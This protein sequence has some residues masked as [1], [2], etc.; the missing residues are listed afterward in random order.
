VS[1]A[2][3]LIAIG[4]GALAGTA[5][6]AVAGPWIA[7]PFG[8]A[9]GVALFGGL[10]LLWYGAVLALGLL[11]GTGTWLAA[12]AM[13]SREAPRSVG[14]AGVLSAG[15]VGIGLVLWGVVFAR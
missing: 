15:I 13:L 2:W 10:G 3:R 11:F 4:Y 9:A 6:L 7:S 8:D 14:N 12:R 1:D 5:A